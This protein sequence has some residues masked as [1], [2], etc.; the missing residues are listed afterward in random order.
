METCSPRDPNINVV[1]TINEPAADGAYQALKAAGKDKDVTI[2]SIDGGCTG[3]SYVKHGIIG[4]TRSS[5][6]R[7][8]P[9]S[10]WR[11]SPSSPRRR[12]AEADRRPGLLQHRPQLVTDQADAGLDEHHHRRRRQICWGK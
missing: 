12:E 10:A 2:V 8:W 7:R 5:T 4:A 3:V 11:R 6:R 9:R 1:Y